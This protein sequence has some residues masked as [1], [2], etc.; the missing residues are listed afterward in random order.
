M[1]EVTLSNIDFSPLIRS[2]DKSVKV[3]TD[4]L[5][6]FTDGFRKMWEHLKEVI[7]RAF[8]NPV[9]PDFSTFSTRFSTPRNKPL[10]PDRKAYL[11][12]NTRGYSSRPM[13]CARSRC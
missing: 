1:T 12:L 8:G 13:Q 6:T 4:V 11:T 10:R 9:V 2:C 7:V 3:I 5:M